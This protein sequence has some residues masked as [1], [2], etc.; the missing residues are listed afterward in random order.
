M[1]SCC[2]LSILY[3][4]HIADFFV[5]FSPTYVFS[6]LRSHACT[7]CFDEILLPLHSCL[8]YSLYASLPTSWLSFLSPLSIL[9]DASVCMDVH[10]ST[11]W[12]LAG[13]TT[14]KTTNCSPSASSCP[15]SITSQPVCLLETLWM[16]HPLESKEQGT[17]CRQL[18]GWG[19]KRPRPGAE[20][21]SLEKGSDCSKGE[22]EM[23]L[24]LQGG[25]WS[26]S[27]N[28]AS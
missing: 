24:S 17:H 18:R 19:T 13:A 7:A 9:S 12:S 11:Y 26:L 27:P 8:T 2:S 16:V 4:L 25:I 21:F 1:P 14:P 22:S 10:G 6:C 5:S 23:Q 15:L 28:P 3:Y 20:G